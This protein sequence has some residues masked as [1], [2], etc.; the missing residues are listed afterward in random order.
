MCSCVVPNRQNSI[1]NA[2][3]KDVVI[4][5][6]ST[7]ESSLTPNTIPD[8]ESDLKTLKQIISSYETYQAMYSQ[9]C[10]LARY[11]L[12]LLVAQH[13]LIIF[14]AVH[15]FVKVRLLWKVLMTEIDQHLL[16][17]NFVT[18]P[19]QFWSLLVGFY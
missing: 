16:R 19:I 1:T 4:S 17:T 14:I 7:P 18:F 13:S 9:L 6:N 15:I 10:C 2:P 3:G 12:C 8:K 11:Q 5:L